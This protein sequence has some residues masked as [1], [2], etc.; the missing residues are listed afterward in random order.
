MNKKISIVLFALVAVASSYYYPKVATMLNTATGFSAKNVC[1]GHFISGFDVQ[2]IVDE[3][4][5][6]VDSAFAFIR[7]KADVQAQSIEAS[8]VGLFSR[9]A[10]YSSGIGCTLLAIDESELNRTVKPLEFVNKPS[11]NILQAN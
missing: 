9:K 2:S 10:V 1:S 5:V 6:P 3:A 7:V 4:L 8:F 11:K